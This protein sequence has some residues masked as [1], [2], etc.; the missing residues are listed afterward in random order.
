MPWIV[1][2]AISHA[3][4]P[5][6]GQCLLMDEHA[7]TASVNR[8]PRVAVQRKSMRAVSRLSSCDGVAGP[9]W[10]VRSTDKR[11]RRGHDGGRGTG[12][13][14]SKVQDIHAR[15]SS[16]QSPYTPTPTHTHREHVGIL[17]N[18]HNRDQQHRQRRR[19]QGAAAAEAPAAAARPAFAHFSRSMAD[20]VCFAP[21]ASPSNNPPSFR[22]TLPTARITLRLLGARSRV[23]RRCTSPYVRAG[24]ADPAR[25]TSNAP[26]ARTHA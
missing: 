6:D 3:G 14:G 26:Y 10:A 9:V 5:R 15:A 18:K 13:G 25:R 17:Y 8:A 7:G 21:S 22:S 16:S 2:A 20:P 24:C 4:W 1:V 19:R 23:C 12:S 11:Q